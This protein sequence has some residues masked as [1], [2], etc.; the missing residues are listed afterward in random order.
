MV[1]SMCREFMF[2]LQLLLSHMLPS[3][4]Y[5]HLLDQNDFTNS[6]LFVQVSQMHLGNKY[7]LKTSYHSFPQTFLKSRCN[8]RHNQIISLQCWH[9]QDQKHFLVVLSHPQHIPNQPNCICE[10]MGKFRVIRLP[11][12]SHNCTKNFVRN[13]FC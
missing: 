11:C 10:T 3:Q 4:A 5:L 8:N 9:T 13:N 7:P 6:S 12:I 2:F 1:S